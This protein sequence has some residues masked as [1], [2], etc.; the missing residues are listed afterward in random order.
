MELLFFY[1]SLKPFGQL[2]FSLTY[3]AVTHFSCQAYLSGKYTFCRKIV[4]ELSILPQDRRAGLLPTRTSD[5]LPTRTSN[6]FID[7]PPL[8][9]RRKL[10]TGLSRDVQTNGS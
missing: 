8:P 5:L 6:M 2:H 7:T 10:F 3:W 9:K 4:C 1:T